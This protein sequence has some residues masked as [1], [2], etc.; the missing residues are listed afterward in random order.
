MRMWEQR[1]RERERERERQ[2]E[3]EREKDREK[4]RDLSA[5]DGDFSPFVLDIFSIKSNHREVCARF[6]GVKLTHKKT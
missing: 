5:G 2:R 3:R 6:G 4:E 1:D